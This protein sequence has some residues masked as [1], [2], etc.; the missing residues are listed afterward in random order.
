MLPE[1][2]ADPNVA[3]RD[4]VET[5]ALWRKMF[6]RDRLERR[7][8]ERDDTPFIVLAVLGFLPNDGGKWNTVTTIEVNHGRYL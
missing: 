1:F 7:T 5:A 8:L 4:N 3:P 6:R 2:A